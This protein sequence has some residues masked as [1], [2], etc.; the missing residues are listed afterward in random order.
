M[1]NYFIEILNLNKNIKKFLTI[2]FDVI[3]I[4]LSC[5]F[6]E[7]IINLGSGP[8]ARSLVLYTFISTIVSICTL[9]F[10]SFYNILSRHFSIKNFSF[11]I[12]LIIVNIFFLIGF[13]QIVVSLY[14]QVTLQ[15]RYFNPNFIILQ[16]ILLII[17]ILLS[18]LLFL[19]ILDLVFRKKNKFKTSII[20]GSEIDEIDLSKNLK[21]N[22]K[23]KLIGFLENDLNKIGRQIDGYKI[24]SYNDLKIISK[25]LKISNCVIIKNKHD[26]NN[27]KNLEFLLK[28]LKIKSIFVDSQNIS[29]DTSFLNFK[30][31]SLK[32][33]NVKFFKNKTVL[34]TGAAGTIG[35]EICLQLEKTKAKKIIGV[36]INEYGVSILNLYLKNKK[37]VK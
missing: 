4:I 1:H 9:Y 12:G 14:P 35:K 10:F 17:L 19:N 37:K 11:L 8:L 23:Y 18:R 3:L 28:K 24:Y 5:L 6:A 25:K 36:D 15:I 32:N 27:L 7:I 20:Y 29:D 34:V 2:N 33:F 16:N 26:S 30:L 13:Q 22:S 21:F 31:Q